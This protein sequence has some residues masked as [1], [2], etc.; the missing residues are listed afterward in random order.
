M[1]L[2]YPD[3]YSGQA[4]MSFKGSAVAMVKATQGT[5]YT[6]PDYWNAKA[7]AAAVG[8]TFCAYH[9]L[10][11][12]N[13]E[14]QADYAFSIVGKGISLMIDW[15]VTNDSNPSVA[16]AQNFVS[17]YKALGG[18]IV[19]NYLPHWYWLELGAPSLEWFASQGMYLVTSDYTSYSDSGVGWVGYGG[20]SVAVW[21][22]TS[23]ASFNGFFPVDF[24]AFKGTQAQFNSLVRGAS[25][26][27]ESLILVE[28]DT[29]SAVTYLE[30]RLNVWGAKLT[31][32]GDFGPLVLAAVKAFQT[33]EKLAVDGEVGPTTWAALDKAP[34]APPTPPPV[35]EYPAPVGFGLAGKMTSIGIKWS[36]VTAK[37]NG[38]LPTGYTVQAWLKDNQVGPSQTVTGTSARFDNLNPG[39][40]YVFKVWANGGELAPPNA[41]ITITA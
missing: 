19:L 37:V 41:E 26:K 20:M 4:Q 39:S 25:V 22:F 1:T 16:D 8:A 34:V 9:F 10:T 29:G 14:G 5:G 15:E 28:G 12:G 21:Q 23:S 24:N 7:R 17:R 6:N 13:G 33:K 2:F 38:K 36:P 3:I 30:Q 31:V 40:T 27:P 32:D 18:T 11:E 35:G